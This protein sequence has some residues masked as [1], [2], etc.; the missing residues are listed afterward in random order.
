MTVTS[1]RPLLWM[2][3]GSLALLALSSIATTAS[4]E[5]CPPPITVTKTEISTVWAGKKKKC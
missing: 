3:L 4:A 1:S 2:T 5:Q